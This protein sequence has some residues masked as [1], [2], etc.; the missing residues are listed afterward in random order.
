MSMLTNNIVNAQDFGEFMKVNR[1][2]PVL[3][4]LPLASSSKQPVDRGRLSAI[5]CC[6]MFLTAAVYAC[7]LF[8]S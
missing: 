1:L 7:P 3:D 8:V 6:L 5:T 2:A 4:Q